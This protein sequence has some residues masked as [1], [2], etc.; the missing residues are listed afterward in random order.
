[1]INLCSAQIHSVRPTSDNRLSLQVRTFR[2]HHRRH[3]LSLKNSLAFSFVI[4]AERRYLPVN[5]IRSA[6]C[7]HLL[8]T[9]KPDVRQV[10]SALRSARDAPFRP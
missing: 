5:L 9:P 7:Q 8:P 2:H 1:M 3:R 4:A 6:A 10:T